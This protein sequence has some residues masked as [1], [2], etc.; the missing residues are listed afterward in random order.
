VPAAWLRVQTQ[1]SHNRRILGNRDCIALIDSATNALHGGSGISR[2]TRVDDS[3]MNRPNEV[4]ADTNRPA[5]IPDAQECHTTLRYLLYLRELTH[6]PTSALRGPHSAVPSSQFAVWCRPNPATSPLNP[7]ISYS[8]PFACR[9]SLKL[10]DATGRLVRVVRT[11]RAASGVS[12]FELRVSCFPPGIYFLS[13]E[14]DGAHA[15]C[16]LTKQ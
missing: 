3:L 1:T 10:Y 8:L 7:S 11:G 5:V 6:G 13:L 15:T 14:T 2:W 9:I 4:Y 12:N 16:K